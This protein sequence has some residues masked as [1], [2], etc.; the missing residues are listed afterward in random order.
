MENKDE[1][2]KGAAIYDDTTSIVTL[3]EGTFSPRLWQELFRLKQ[4]D[5]LSLNFIN[6]IEYYRDHTLYNIDAYH[7][8]VTNA[9][10]ENFLYFFC[11]HEFVIPEHHLLAYL[12]LQPIICH[13]V[14]VSDF[15]TTTPWLTR[16]ITRRENYFKV[17]ALCNSRT[18][19]EIEQ[20]V[21]FE[22]SDVFSSQWWSYYWLSTVSYCKPSTY[23]RI[24][25]H[26]NKLDPRYILFGSNSRAS[27]F[28]VTYVAPEL[29]HTIKSKLNTLAAQALSNVE[30]KNTPNKKHIAIITSRWYQ[31]AVYTSL[32]P[33]LH[34]LKGHYE[35]T[36]IH[37]GPPNNDL[38]DKEMFTNTLHIQMIQ[39]QM[40]LSCI[41][42]NSFAAVIYP[43]IGMC[44]ESIFLSNI[45]IAP[46]QVVMY[47]HPSST[48]DSLIDYFIVGR[49]SED[50][51]F[52]QQ[53]YSERMV[54][55]PG[56]GVCPVFPDYPIPK[57]GII[58]EEETLLINCPWTSQKITWPLIEAL[59][60]ILRN[61]KRKIKF[62]FFSGGGL[63]NANAFIPFAKDLW[64][65]LGRENVNIFPPLQKSDYLK[66]M[67]K[68]SLSIDSYPFGGFNT[69]IDSLHLRKPV[70]AWKGNY[71]FSRFTSATLD[72]LGLNELIASSREEYIDLTLRLI[73]DSIYRNNICAKIDTID[74]KK[75]FTENENPDYFCKAIDYLIEHSDELKKDISKT[76]LMIE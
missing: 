20:S 8:C 62:Q 3:G 44:T 28:P 19:F 5:Q 31:S 26:L 57:S 69:I 76:P 40:D 56:M 25:N 61:S 67:E 22:I 29:E 35:L 47:G 71:A 53:Y 32:A 12:Q 2:A 36:L 27:Y 42:E 6:C 10:V 75:A 38:L 60:E 39:D 11:N 72:L 37:L 24:R 55:L 63:T 64:H 52:A 34:S 9:F 58:N 48:H 46:I 51:M 66:E 7:R 74:I 70:V 49:K 43:D 16:L 17:L 65:L 15:E 45:R 41:H 73:H 13:I 68:G 30:I 1:P 4:F 59:Q 50:L 33:M 14:G 23:N 18:E 54:V 21:L